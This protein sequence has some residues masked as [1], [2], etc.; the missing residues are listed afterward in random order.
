MQKLENRSLNKYNIK[1]IDRK[2]I[3]G[4]VVGIE[5][6]SSWLKHK[7]KILDKVDNKQVE[8]RRLI[9]KGTGRII[10][11][12][13]EEGNYFIAN[14]FM[15]RYFNI[16]P[17]PNDT[18]KLIRYGDSN[19]NICWDY[20]GP[21]I[22]TLLDV[23]DP[24]GAVGLKNND[25]TT[26]YQ[27]DDKIIDF[28]GDTENVKKV[29][30]KPQDISI[31]GRGSAELLIS[32]I[33]KNKAN[34]HEAIML[35]SGRFLTYNNSKPAQYNKKNSFVRVTIEPDPVINLKN[36]KHIRHIYEP[37]YDETLES[38]P[39]VG[40][41]KT[42]VDI[43]GEKIYLFSHPIKDVAYSIPYAELLFQ[44]LSQLESWL[45][46]HKHGKNGIPAQSDEL[47]LGGNLKITSDGFIQIPDS[48]SKV[49]LTTNIKII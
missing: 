39:R 12:I 27:Y 33:Q 34:P 42:R 26:N 8:E 10:V 13:P 31:Q 20:I 44:Y 38:T 17:S 15:P 11:Y 16:F 30:P 5:G 18:V 23:N 48:G 14:P 24:S 43:V 46:N 32:K 45:I 21:V 49:A 41:I 37:K 22:P 28:I 36:T 2:V 6:D 4:L 9:D 3:L 29:Y 1:N 7:Q 25:A 40:E 35:R 47:K 19:Q